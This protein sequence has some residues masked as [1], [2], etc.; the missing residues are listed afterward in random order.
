MILKRHLFSEDAR[1]FRD[2]LIQRVKLGRAI[3]TTKNGMIG[4]LKREGIFDSLPKAID[5]ISKKRRVVLNTIKFDNQ[6]YL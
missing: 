2:I 3:E 4:Y 5:N 6:K 1:T